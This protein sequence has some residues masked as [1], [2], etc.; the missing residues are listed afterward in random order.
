MDKPEQPADQTGCT[1]NEQGDRYMKNS[2]RSDPCE[3]LN[4]L[5]IDCVSTLLC[6][7]KRIKKFEKREAEKQEAEETLLYYRG[8][9]N[10]C[11]K[12]KPSVMRDDKHYENEGAMLRDLMTRQP[13]EFS[14]FASALDRWMIAQHH[15]LR[16]RFLDIS[17]N[18]LVGLYFACAESEKEPDKSKEE[19]NKSS[20]SL[21]S[22]SCSTDNPDKS[23]A[24]A[25]GLLY[26]FATKRKCVKPYD[27]D[28]VSIVANFARLRRDE[29][30]AILNKTEQ[31]LKDRQAFVG[32]YRRI[33]RSD[34]KVVKEVRDYADYMDRSLRQENEAFG[35]YSDMGRLWTFIKQEKPYFVEGL[36]KPRDL[37]RIFIVQPRR[38]FPRARAQSGAFLVSAYQKRFDFEFDLKSKEP[39]DRNIWFRPHDW[40]VPYNYYRLTVKAGCKESIREELKSLNISE[41][42]L[43]PELDKSAKAIVDDYKS[44]KDAL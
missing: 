39:H 16:T 24:K 8:Q 31:F 38:L 23:K 27:S 44:G 43:C 17:A 29:Q 10:A 6:N 18:P 36:I 4:L 14:N 2:E 41:Y 22:P 5:P 3:Q 37:F 33:M 1:K 9:S 34:P 25:D 30:R 11:W 19:T 32:P 20:S 13:D 35:R 21:C 26:V 7:I 15:G 28:S 12:L 40:D 42:T